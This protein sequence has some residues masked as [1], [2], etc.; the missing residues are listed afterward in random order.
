LNLVF[1]T[2]AAPLTALHIWSYIFPFTNWQGATSGLLTGFAT[3]AFLF[4]L[5]VPTQEFSQLCLNTTTIISS[6]ILPP[7]WPHFKIENPEFNFAPAVLQTALDETQKWLPILGEIPV[8]WHPLAAFSKPK[9]ELS[10]H[11]RFKL[12]VHKKDSGGLLRCF[13]KVTRQNILGPGFTAMRNKNIVFPHYVS[14]E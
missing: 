1:S 7:V 13:M 10:I 9:H 2:L 8:M 3:A 14:S 11:M 4:Y 6:P 12:S 5:Y